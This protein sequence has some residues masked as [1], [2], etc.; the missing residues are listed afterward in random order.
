MNLGGAILLGNL[1]TWLTPIWLL[2]M[3]A[4]VGLVLLGIIV[5]VVFLISRRAGRGLIDSL[6]EGVL[7]PIGYVAA[8]MAGFA[9]LVTFMVPARALL[10]STLQLPF[11][12]QVPSTTV[13]V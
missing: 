13:T 8:F 4:L 9:L 11:S 2:G 3:G 7:L 1:S 6:R 10:E 12:G 5:A